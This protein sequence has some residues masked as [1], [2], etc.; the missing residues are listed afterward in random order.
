MCKEA[1][2]DGKDFGCYNVKR[3]PTVHTLYGIELDK[4]PSKTE[5]GEIRSK[6]KATE[7]LS[8]SQSINFLDTRRTIDFSWDDK[9]NVSK[10][11]KYN[12]K[13]MFALK[14]AFWFYPRNT[15]GF[16][17]NSGSCTVTNEFLKN[18]QTARLI[19][20]IEDFN[21]DYQMKTITDS[22]KSWSINCWK[23]FFVYAD[24]SYYRILANDETHLFI[25]DYDDE[26]SLSA[27]TYSIDRIKVRIQNKDMKSSNILEMWSSMTD[28]LPENNFSLSLV[29]VDE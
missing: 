7:V 24:N 1:A 2:S 18:I 21:I 15:T 11:M 25:E 28:A 27:N 9:V 10:Q 19:F 26:L 23:G 4:L 5:F 14:K 16:E 22:T 3:T 6:Y 12:F 13:F 20:N 8:G 29:E 17:E